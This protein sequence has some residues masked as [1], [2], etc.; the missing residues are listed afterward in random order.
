MKSGLMLPVPNRHHRHVDPALFTPVQVYLGQVEA[1]RA[2]R[3]RSFRLLGST[4]EV[5]RGDLN[6]A[7]LREVVVKLERGD[8]VAWNLLP[9]VLVWRPSK[10]AWCRDLGGA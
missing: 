4:I 8:S 3:Q 2:R 7:A 6:E 9:S 10:V 1:A 5:D